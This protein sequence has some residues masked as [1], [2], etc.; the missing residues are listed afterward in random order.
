MSQTNQKDLLIKIFAVAGTI[1]VWT[2]IV[3]TIVTAIIGTISD[4]R[5]RFDYLMPAELFPFALA[6]SL[7]LFWAALRAHSKQKLIGWGLG[8]A[9]FFLIGG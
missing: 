6:G 1:L 3:F 4:H 9:L 8:A 5:L 7:L 2:P